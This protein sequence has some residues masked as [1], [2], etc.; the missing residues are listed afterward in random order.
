MCVCAS[1]SVFLCLCARVCVSV[2]MFLCLCAY[3][4]VHVSV[5]MCTHLLLLADITLESE[6]ISLQQWSKGICQKRPTHAFFR[7]NT[8]GKEVSNVQGDITFCVYVCVYVCIPT[9]PKWDLQVHEF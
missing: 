6:K 2:S 3:L 5:C 4:C 1:V 9:G 7:V 8:V